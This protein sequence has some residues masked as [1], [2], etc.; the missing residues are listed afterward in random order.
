MPNPD[1]M[2]RLRREQEDALRLEDRAR[3]EELK[4]KLADMERE[5]VQPLVR[6]YSWHHPLPFG[7]S[8]WVKKS[9]VEPLVQAVRRLLDNIYEFGAPTEHDYVDPV[10]DQLLKLTGDGG[11]GEQGETCDCDR[12]VIHDCVCPYCR[13][14]YLAAQSAG[15]VGELVEAAEK[16]YQL[17]DVMH[18][19]GPSALIVA[20]AMID[21][22]RAAENV[23][24]GRASKP[25]D[26]GKS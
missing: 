13:Q 1:D 15:G 4:K 19:D 17:R 23:R 11:T 16:V 25:S 14:R 8:H 12:T 3:V 18:A 24:Q 10:E 22:Q 21:L 26:V 2:D 7:D 5:L 20:L 6:A 9:D